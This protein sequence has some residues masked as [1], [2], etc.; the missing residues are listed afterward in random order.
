MF[1]S[2]L[3]HKYEGLERLRNELEILKSIYETTKDI[4]VLEEI[5]YL[6]EVIDYTY[7]DI[8]HSEF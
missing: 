2:N 7:L 3:Q 8:A 5:K 6:E 4:E 1:K